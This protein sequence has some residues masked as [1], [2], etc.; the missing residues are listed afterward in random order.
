MLV[1]ASPGSSIGRRAIPWLRQF[2][3]LPEH[4]LRSYPAH[5]L[6]HIAEARA[7]L[8]LACLMP[9]IV[10]L[11]STDTSI[12]FW[13]FISSANSP[14]SNGVSQGPEAPEEERRFGTRNAGVAPELAQA[15]RH[16]ETQESERSQ[17]QRRDEPDFAEEQDARDR[18]GGGNEHDG[19]REAIDAFVRDSAGVPYASLPGS[20]GGSHAKRARRG[21]I[22]TR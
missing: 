5:R 16:T 22:R 14:R 20:V 1:C 15:T 3:H 19:D 17:R 6:Q 9:A 18:D 2:H 8:Q 4:E 21:F 7:N 11:T 13:F 12:P 10:R